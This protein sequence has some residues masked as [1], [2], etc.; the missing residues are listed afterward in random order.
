MDELINKLEDYEAARCS[1]KKESNCSF[2][3]SEKINKRLDWNVGYRL[4][5]CM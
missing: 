4:T 2:N 1:F 3:S 5:V